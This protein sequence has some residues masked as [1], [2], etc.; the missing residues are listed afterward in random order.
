MI[1]RSRRNVPT[2]SREPPLYAVVCCSLGVGQQL[3][4]ERERDMGETGTRGVVVDRH[5]EERERGVRVNQ[6]I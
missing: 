2:T 1:T 4:I 6:S 5:H 3:L